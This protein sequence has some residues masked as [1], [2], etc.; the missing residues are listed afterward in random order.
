LGGSGHDDDTI[1]E[2]HRAVKAPS[3]A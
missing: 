3:T 1:L 2:A